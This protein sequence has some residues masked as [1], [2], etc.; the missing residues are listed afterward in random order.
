MKYIVAVIFVIWVEQFSLA[1]IVPAE[2]RMK[3]DK[4]D[5]YMHENP[6]D[7]K[8]K[9]ETLQS[10]HENENKNDFWL[11]IGKDFVNA[12]T[13]KRLNTNKAK[14]VIF[15]LADGMS[16]ATFNAARVVVGGEEKSMSF[17]SFPHMGMVRTYC[18]D[19]QVPDSSCTSTA[20][21]TGVK[22]NYGTVGLSA[23]VPRFDC[24]GQLDT[25]NQTQSIFKWAL[26]S[27]KS[28]GI[29]TTD[30]VT[31]ASPAG[32]FAHSANRYWENDF[33]ITKNSCDPNEIDDIAKQLIRG[34]VGSRLQ[35]ILG[36]GRGHMRNDTVTDE[37]G[38]I[39]YRNDGLDL[40]EEYLERNHSRAKYVWNAT[41]F[42]SVNPEDVDYLLGLFEKGAM[43]YNREV[44]ED[45]RQ[46]EEPTLAEM[47]EKAIDVLSKNENG[48]FLFVEGQKIDS[49]HHGNYA[50]LSLDEVVEFSKAVDLARNKV[51]EE[52]T[53]IVVTSD[54][55]H[56]VSY[57]G[58]GVRGTDIFGSAE[59]SN[60]DG[61][62][63]M[64]L[65]Y[66]NGG[67]YSNHM[68]AEEKTRIDL[69]T[70]NT[71]SNRFQFPAGL[72][73][74]SET[75]AGDD[76]AVF[77]SGPW[78]HLFSGVYE[79]NVIPYLIAYAACIGEGISHS[80]S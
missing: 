54:H 27:G 28:A 4:A 66:A 62:P 59:R 73:L 8:T 60:M 31:G 46:N 70:V 18:V 72:P 20:Y 38:V 35:V 37:E 74:S 52:D 55:S 23:K 50:R 33:E 42:R 43:M 29:V 47:T 10:A 12:Q 69:S 34:D 36:G 77:T 68:S 3:A 64:K 13:T 5:R 21:L 25:Q 6:E 15:F 65:M 39:G 63:Y 78:S 71:S 14:N 2:I 41:E 80:C 49:A 44:V 9:A 11:N 30:T 61:K 53:L 57:N 51:N 7:S 19:Y 22:A 40:I 75:H 24:T 67:G 16:V 48:Y 17:E 58:Y 76:V 79:Q 32:V 56:T 1:N 45:G 26:D